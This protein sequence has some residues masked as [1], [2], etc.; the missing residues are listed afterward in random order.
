MALNAIMNGNSK[1]YQSSLS[2]LLDI[3]GSEVVF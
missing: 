2:P 3:S 1:H